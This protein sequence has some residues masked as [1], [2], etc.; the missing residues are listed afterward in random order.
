MILRKHVVKEREQ[1]IKKMIEEMDENA[2]KAKS[3]ITL[4]IGGTKFV[5]SK[6]TL[7]MAKDSY[8]ASMLRSGHFQV[9]LFFKTM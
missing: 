8:F 9:R 2:S 1:K 4:D 3:K 5:T 6:T 7:M